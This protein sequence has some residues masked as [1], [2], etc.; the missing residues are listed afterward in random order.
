MRDISIL[1][2][3][4]WSPLRKTYNGY[5]LTDFGKAALRDAMTCDCHP[6]FVGLLFTCEGCGTVYGLWREQMPQRSQR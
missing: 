4:G 5:V 6:R 3:G 2:K 1:P